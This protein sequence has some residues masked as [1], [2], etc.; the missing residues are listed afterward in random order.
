MKTMPQQLS[1]R[2]VEI[3][4]LSMTRERLRRPLSDP[5]ALADL[6]EDERREYRA[7]RREIQADLD[8]D[9]D[10]DFGPLLAALEEKLGQK[11]VYETVF[12][13][14]RFLPGEVTY[15]I[16]ADEVAQ[17]LKRLGIEG[18]EAW[19]I[20]RLVDDGLLP[21]PPQ[22]GGGS[23]PRNAYFA[24]HVVAA[25]YRALFV[26]EKPSELEAEVRVARGEVPEA[27]VAYLRALPRTDPAILSRLT[28]LRHG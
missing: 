16:S 21:P 26:S 24:R 17:V 27:T 15:P 22:A 18:L 2:A 13:P 10:P 23:L 4:R 1:G 7:V 28:Q 9:Q 5:G 11:R 6:S 20:E 14:E 8:M 12:H 3:A 19:T 25:A